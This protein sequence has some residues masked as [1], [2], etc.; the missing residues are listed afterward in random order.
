MH[1]YTC[2][3]CT[4]PLLTFRLHGSRHIRPGHPLTSCP[5]CL[6]QTLILVLIAAH[7]GAFLLWVGLLIFNEAK[8]KKTLKKD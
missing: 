2:Y 7:I 1:V 6:V 8:S 4:C 3:A 5:A